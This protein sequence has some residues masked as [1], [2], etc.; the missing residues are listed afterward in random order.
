MVAGMTN[1]IGW[2]LA[3]DIT[4]ANGPYYNLFLR[5]SVQGVSAENQTGVKFSSNGVTYFAPNANT[6][7]GGRVGQCT[8]AGFL[9]AG[10]GNVISGVAVENQTL[11]GIAYSFAGTASIAGCVNNVVEG[12]Y[13]EGADKV[14]KFSANTAGNQVGNPYIT[15][16][17]TIIDDSGTD[18]LYINANVP[19]R[20]PSGVKFGTKSTDTTV[21]DYY[22]ESTWTA[23]VSGSGTAGT[24]ELQTNQCQYI[25]IGRVVHLQ[26]YLKFAGAVTGGGTGYLKITGLPFQKM[27]NSLPL[28]SI[29]LDG[30]D[31]AAS[32][33]LSV[34]FESPGASS[35]LAINETNDNAASTAVQI[36]GVAAN[37]SIFFS[38]TYMVGTLD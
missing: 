1:A 15:G 18:N 9:I 31:Y 29:T 7:I 21:L 33:S 19:S 22:A 10:A 30:V 27:S 36:A 37:D 32:A 25:R 35:T 13:V 14:F 17:T 26:A 23:V 11:T 3:T 12:G 24:Y 16:A 5:C 20:L 8:A 6:W 2:K 34:G 28:G 4:I 38:I